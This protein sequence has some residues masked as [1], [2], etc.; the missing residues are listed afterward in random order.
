V[1]VHVEEDCPDANV[2]PSLALEIL[3]NLM[4]NA[5]RVSAP[6]LPVELVARAHP[7]NGEIG[8]LEVLDRG[9]GLPPNIVDAEGLLLPGAATDVAQRGLGLEI[10]RSL[11]IANGGTIGITPRPGGGS[12]ARLDFPAAPLPAGAQ[13]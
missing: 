6:G 10:A 2:D 3:V 11:T 13:A 5:H 1:T 4:E 12:I 7:L 8:R 9:P